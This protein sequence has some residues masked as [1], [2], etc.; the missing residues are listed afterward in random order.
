MLPGERGFF[1]VR[2]VHDAALER[3]G[4]PEV[5]QGQVT[6]QR[7]VGQVHPGEAQPGSAV[8]GIQQI[9][10]EVAALVQ[11]GRREA[12]GAIHVTGRRPQRIAIA[13][14]RIGPGINRHVPAPGRAEEGEVPV[15]RGYHP[16]VLVLVRISDPPSA[17][18]LE[19][20]LV[21]VV[22]THR[23]V[24]ASAAGAGVGV[25]AQPDDLVTQA[26]QRDD[27]VVARWL[28]AGTGVDAVY[29]V[30]LV[31]PDVDDTALV[32]EDPTVDVGHGVPPFRSSG[33]GR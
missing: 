33:A 25:A 16:E 11:G 28:A 15:A 12:R 21:G 24:A 1:Q 3:G 31:V 17:G 19:L 13:G 4:P 6:A 18:R 8:A 2:A 7:A 30:I 14:F 27:V 5:T 23:R 26:D 9:C 29:R 20:H 32:A 10:D 22:V